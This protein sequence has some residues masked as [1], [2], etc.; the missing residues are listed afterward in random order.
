MNL[1]KQKEDTWSREQIVELFRSY[2]D[3]MQENL[4]SDDTR[5]K[6]HETGIESVDD[7]V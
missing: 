1:K 3:K 6:L 2:K 4:K 7:S 5:H